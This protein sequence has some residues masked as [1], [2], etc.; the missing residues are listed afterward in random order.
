[1]VLDADVLAQLAEVR[2]A[3]RAGLLAMLGDAAGDDGP[4]Y[5][6]SVLHS[7]SHPDLRCT[8]LIALAKRCGD[9]A[10]EEYQA[11]CSSRSLSVRDYGVL[12]LAAFG[13]DR[14]WSTMLARL[15]AWRRRKQADDPPAGAVLVTYLVCH[16]TSGERVVELV[17]VV[18][19]VWDKLLP[20]DRKVVERFWPDAPPD[21][22]AA[23]QV[24][25]PDARG[26][27]TW[28]RRKPIF[29]PLAQP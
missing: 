19:A 22:P 11:A 17:S 25:S 20:S 5:L 18:R 9:G 29:G 1:M 4:A 10:T 3:R 12:T 28:L 21:G 7:E 14:A 24:G 16:A 26:M 27:G 6:R 2:G 13:D 23:A 15:S 8:A